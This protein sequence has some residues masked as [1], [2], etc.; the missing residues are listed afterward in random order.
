MGETVK[1]AGVATE[2]PKAVRVRLEGGPVSLYEAYRLPGMSIDVKAGGA[3]GRVALASQPARKA[4]EVL[5][6]AEGALA[7]ALAPGAAVEVSPPEGAGFPVFDFRRHD[8]YLVGHGT[9]LAAGR[10]A[11]LHALTERGAFDR[12]CVLA[13][14]RFL[15]EIP[16]RE[17]FP[18]WQRAGVRVYQVLARPDMAKW[19]KGEGAYVF[20]L[21]RELE[22]DPKKSVVFAS[23]GEV[24]LRGVQGVC[25][26]AGIP[27]QKVFL[28]ELMTSERARAMEPERPPALLAKIA[29]E[30]VFGSGHQPDAPD[31]AP[32]FRTP[33]EQPAGAG[34]APYQKTKDAHA[35]H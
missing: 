1:V 28:H 15:D 10:A 16:F 33:R 32:V 13:E 12:L 24:L 21:L 17:E 5:L 22:P 7:K 4:F 31:H 20:D 30:G 3:A 29:A 19:K 35:G 11:A 34:P 23:G 18:A 6:D 2:T 27:P 25:R 8:V 9:G 26:A 14:A